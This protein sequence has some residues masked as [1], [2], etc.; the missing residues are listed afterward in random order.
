M[1]DEMIQCRD[2][3]TEFLFTEGELAFYV[4]KGYQPPKRCKPCRDKRKN[5]QA[6]TA[7]PAPQQPPQYA[8]DDRDSR[9][10]G[11]RKGGRRD[12]YNE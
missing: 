5:Q 7:Q 2:C 9:R 1:S 4:E 8:A 6:A 3:P 10:G 12:N 11:G